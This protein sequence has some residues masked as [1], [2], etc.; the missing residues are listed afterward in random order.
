MER[1]IKIDSPLNNIEMAKK[2]DHK[3]LITDAAINKV[4]NV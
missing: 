4:P 3:I 1:K 2:R